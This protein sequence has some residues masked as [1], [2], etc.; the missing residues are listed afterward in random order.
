[1]PGGAA[2]VP[3]GPDAV[4]DGN[5]DYSAPDNN[6]HYT[7]TDHNDAAADDDDDNAAANPAAATAAAAAGRVGDPCHGAVDTGMHHRQPRLQ[8]LPVQSAIGH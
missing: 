3:G 7:G 5:N 4:P 8:G 2:D 1:M 6:N